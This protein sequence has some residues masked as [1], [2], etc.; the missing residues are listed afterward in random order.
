MCQNWNSKAFK[1][2]QWGSNSHLKNLQF[3]L[4]E[5]KPGS[6][7][8]FKKKPHNSGVYNLQQTSP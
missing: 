1:W 6:Q 2:D 4:K 3:L 5:S 7:D 8:F